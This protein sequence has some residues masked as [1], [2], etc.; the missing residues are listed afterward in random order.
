MLA[1]HKM[2]MLNNKGIKQ[3]NTSLILRIVREKG[4]ISRAHISKIT[5]LNPATVS[6]NLVELLEANLVREVGSGESSGG[7]KPTLLELNGS[8]FGVIAIDMGTADIHAAAVDLN[9]QVLLQFTL[10]LQDLKQP[11]EVLAVMKDAIQKVQTK[12][13]MVSLLGIGVGAHG[14]VDSDKGISIYAPAYQWE[15]IPMA[16]MLKE[17]FHLPVRVDN[18]VRA[19]ALAEKWFG[20]AKGL[21]DFIYLNLGTGIGSGIYLK[22]ELI[23]GASFGAGEIGH[24]H[25]TDEADGISCFCGKKGCLSTVASGPAVVSRFKQRLE[26]GA[27]SLLREQTETI[28][29]EHI[30]EAALAGDALA[31]EILEETG[32]MIGHALSIAVNLVNPEQIIIGGGLSRA[33]QFIFPPIRRFIEARA[34]QNNTAHLVIRRTALGDQSGIIGAGTLVI[35]DVFYR[36][37]QFIQES[38]KR[39]EIIRE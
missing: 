5:G 16:A 14:L 13:K 19:M 18:D 20:N 39:E 33:E 22:D 6:S 26:N 32:E 4:P 1:A 24:I 21:S 37:E 2:Y 17:A 34:M 8:R 38:L 7:R 35:R 23:S 11:S 10:P 3:A 12:A 25:V 9:G 29:G 31:I 27:A 30:Y 15:H 36:P 28:T